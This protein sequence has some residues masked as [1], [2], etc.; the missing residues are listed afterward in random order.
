LL[1]G[2]GP[3]RVVGPDD[4]PADDGPDD[5]DEDLDRLA[6]PLKAGRL[7]ALASDGASVFLEFVALAHEAN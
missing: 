7:A 6:E 5:G 4:D 2:F 3:R 1:T